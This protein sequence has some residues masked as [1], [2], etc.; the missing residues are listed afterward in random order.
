METVPRN[1]FDWKHLRFLFRGRYFL[2]AGPGFVE[3]DLLGD[4]E[5]GGSWC[6]CLD[7]GEVGG[8]VVTSGGGAG[9]AFVAAAAATPAVAATA[10]AVALS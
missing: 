4:G 9:G 2:L 10:A 5:V 3:Y 7:G 8:V 6:S 1:A